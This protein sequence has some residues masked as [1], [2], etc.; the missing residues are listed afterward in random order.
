MYFILINKSYILSFIYNFAISVIN[1]SS[2]LGSDNNEDIDN[3][4]FAT[5]NAGDQLVFKISKQIPPFSLI[6]QW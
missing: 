5:V 1:G 3:N 6:L 4:T 2:G